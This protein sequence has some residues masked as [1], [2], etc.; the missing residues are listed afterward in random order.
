MKKVIV[1]CVAALFGTV[2]M[3]QVQDSVSYT[4]QQGVE[5][6]STDQELDQATDQMEDA[7]QDS[8]DDS[9][10]KLE[11]AREDVK[12]GAERTGEGIKEGAD[13][14]GD[15]TKEGAEKSGNAIERAAKN[16]AA[17]VKDEQLESKQGPDGEAI[18]ID[19]N[20]QY[21]YISKETGERVNV[22]KSELKDRD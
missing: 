1:A 21:Y 5:T 8:R 22:E 14:V 17:H 2:A 12:E 6:Q 7:W 13:A 11:Q 9:A 18:F 4:P 3:A 19:E 16:G 15:K 10:E 20:A